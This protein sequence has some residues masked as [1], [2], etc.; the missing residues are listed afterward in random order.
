VAHCDLTGIPLPEAR[1]ALAR[2]AA[3]LPYPALNLRYCEG[4]G[5]VEPCVL[6][7]LFGPGD[8]YGGCRRPGCCE[9]N[10][11]NP[12]QAAGRERHWREVEPHSFDTYEWA[13]GPLYPALYPK[14]Q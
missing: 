6:A 2:I 12:L 10:Y 8:F 13:F 3:D 14:D 1:E 7:T 9:Q 5:R 11:H 4:C